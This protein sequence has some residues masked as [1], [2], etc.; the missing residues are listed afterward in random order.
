MFKIILKNLWNRRRSNAWLFIELIIITV[1]SWYMIDP[2]VVS[3][4]QSLFPNG[5][6]A[7][8]LVAFNVG[9]LPESSPA[10][11]AAAAKDSASVREDFDRMLA[12]VASFDGASSVC[13]TTYAYFGSQGV[14]INGSLAEGGTGENIT[15]LNSY[16]IPHQKFFE[17]YGISTLP[18]SPSPEELSEIGTGVVIT[19]DLAEK[20]WPGENAVNK[21]L[22]N[23]WNE[24]TNYVQVVGVVENVKYNPFYP[25]Y[26]LMMA[27]LELDLDWPGVV[28]VRLEKGVDKKQFVRDALSWF[29]DNLGVTGNFYLRSG[30]TYEELIDKLGK[31]QDYTMRNRHI[32]LSLFFLVNLILG[33]VGSF[34]LQIRRRVGEMGVH[35]SFGARSRH[36]FG[37]VM[38][39]SMTLTVVSFLIGDLLYLQYALKNGLSVGQRSWGDVLQ[40]DSWLNSFPQHFAIV[41]AIILLIL[42]VCVAIGTF[43]PARRISRINPVDALRDE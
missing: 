8:S 3:V 16:Y 7:D 43:F 15:Y 12:T 26:A 11:N 36:I 39:E 14:S 23:T 33:V 28:A 6:D 10:Y 18:G 13:T 32:V 38:G 42:L 17:T 19:R 25:S 22:Y 37:M 4:R 29:S 20:Y 24:D 5:Y 2:T 41:S 34:Y 35:R 30:S 9:R 27:P 1:V 31:E 40:I 21:R